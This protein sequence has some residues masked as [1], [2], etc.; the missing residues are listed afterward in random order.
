MIKQFGHDLLDQVIIITLFPE[1]PSV[2]LEMDA[3]KYLVPG[4]C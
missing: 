4:P 1:V 2:L 3:Q